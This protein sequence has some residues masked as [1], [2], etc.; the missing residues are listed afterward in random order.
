MQRVRFDRVLRRTCSNYEDRRFWQEIPLSKK[1]EGVVIGVRTLSEGKVHYI[2]EE[3]NYYEHKN[4]VFALLVV[5]SPYRNPV[6]VLPGSVER[7]D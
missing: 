5:F 1:L 2:Y 7:I 4:N 6:Y 3:G